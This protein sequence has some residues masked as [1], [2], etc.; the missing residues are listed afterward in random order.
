[1]RGNS[2]GYALS[3]QQHPVLDDQSHQRQEVR[4]SD[5]LAA[6]QLRIPYIHG[7]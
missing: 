3:V 4:R 2:I 1:M 7:L 6:S 5:R